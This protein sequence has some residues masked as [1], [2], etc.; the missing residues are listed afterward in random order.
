MDMNAIRLLFVED[1]PALRMVV[2]E[3]LEFEGFHVFQADDGVSGLEIFYNENID[4]VVADIMMPNLD[5]LEMVTRM[6]QRNRLIPII[7]LTAKSSVESVVEGFNVG[8]DDYLRK[9]FSMREL[10][11]RIRALYA[12]VGNS[13][14]TSDFS[15]IIRVGSFLFDPVSQFLRFKDDIESLS[16]KE[17]EILSL[18]VENINDVV[19]TS[20]IMKTLWG[21][22]SISVNNSL[23]VFMTRLRQR[24]KRDPSVR[25]VN[26]R[27]IGYKLT[28]D[29]PGKHGGDLP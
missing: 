21:D 28:I 24:L 20:H 9:P 18:L 16:S 5:G 10:I 27:G 15:N 23:Q 14:P 4:V 1:D 8:A 29:M 7:F 11:V 12:R 2:C 26:A 17:N 25:I 22:D 6:R 13:R 19:T 3:T